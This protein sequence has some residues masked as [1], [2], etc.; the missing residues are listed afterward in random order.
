MILLAIFFTCIYLLCEWLNGSF[1][2]NIVF[3]LLFSQE[4]KDIYVI[5]TSSFFRLLWISVSFSL[6]VPNLCAFNFG[7]WIFL[8]KGMHTQCLLLLYLIE[9]CVT[10]LNLMISNLAQIT[11][12]I[13]SSQRHFSGHP[14]WL[15]TRFSYI[16]ITQVFCKV[17]VS[18]TL[19]WTTTVSLSNIVREMFNFFN[20]NLSQLFLIWV[21]A[22]AGFQLSCPH[23][24]HSNNVPILPEKDGHSTEEEKKNEDGEEGG[25]QEKMKEKRNFVSQQE[26]L[27]TS[28]DLFQA[29]ASMSNS[30]P[31]LGGSKP[32][33][34]ISHRRMFSLEPFHQSSIISSRLKRG[35]EEEREEEREEDDRMGSPNKKTKLTN[36][37]NQFI[38]RFIWI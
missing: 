37:M 15:H 33:V 3:K 14:S 7:I 21:S 10:C 5:K 19:T 26:Q 17:F 30:V 16:L 24:H 36:G 34:P 25:L 35:R 28:R 6:F 13:C 18:E 23:S 29:N 22:H 31:G 11:K 9:A 27:P 2:E 12:N 1:W 38:S 20:L 32:G 8:L 4:V